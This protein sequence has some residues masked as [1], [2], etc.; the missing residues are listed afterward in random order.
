VAPIYTPKTGRTAKARGFVLIA[1]C[2]TLFLLMA[3]IGLAFD[4]GRV[5]IVHNEAQIFA[6]AA[7]LAAAAKLDGTSAG[8]ARAREAVAKLP[9]RWNFGGTPFRGVIVE[10]S[11]DGTRWD[12]SPEHEGS[13]LAELRMARVS[14][15]SN[16]V[17]ITFLRAV[18]A[19][20]S[21]SVGAR[22]V[23]A[24]DPVRLIQ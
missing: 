7:A 22:S 14:A 3:A 24:A 20:E 15:P 18:G 21:L 12:A 13:N 8:L 19:P 5:Y 2:A 23:A 6:D 4:F 9:A 17:D 16:E 1:L 11:A 10:F